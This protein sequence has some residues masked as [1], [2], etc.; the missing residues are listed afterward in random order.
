MTQDRFN[1]A[2]NIRRGGAEPAREEAETRRVG[3]FCGPR[4]VIDNT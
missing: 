1:I 4:V 2:Q 3:P